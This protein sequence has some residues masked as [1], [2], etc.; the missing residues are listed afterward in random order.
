MSPYE[1]MTYNND[2]NTLDVYKI[3]IIQNMNFTTNKYK[4]GLY[5]D[6]LALQTY[7]HVFFIFFR[8]SQDSK[9]MSEIQEFY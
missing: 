1:D 8:M 7:I 2:L 3:V 5:F 4:A 6:L 9:E